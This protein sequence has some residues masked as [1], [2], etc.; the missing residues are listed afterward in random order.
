MTASLMAILDSIESW[1]AK[2]DQGVFI[3]A[4]I[5]N[6]IYKMA[7]FTNLPI[8]NLAGIYAL[9]CHLWKR[10][11]GT[12]PPQTLCA[13]LKDY[14]DNWGAYENLSDWASEVWREAETN[15]N[16]QFLLIYVVS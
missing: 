10:F 5:L 6:P 3:A 12:A 1:W 9:L 8:L 4:I 11:Y 16:F 14:I 7:P 15:V 2:C 13:E